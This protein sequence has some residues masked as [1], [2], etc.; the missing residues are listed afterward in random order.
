MSL[1]PQTRIAYP[2]VWS[3]LFLI[4]GGV[5]IAYLTVKD[6]FLNGFL[7]IGLVLGVA[8]VLM[9]M[10]RYIW[11]I[12][13]LFF[14]SIFMIYI[15]RA[16]HSD[17]PTGVIYDFFIAVS[18][19]SVIV[20]A[21]N[22]QTWGSF[23]NPITWAFFILMFY[24]VLEVLNP[25][26]T[27]TAWGVSLRKVTYFLLFVLSMQSVITNRGLHKITYAWFGFA[28]LVA[29]YGIYQEIFG[30]TTQEYNWVI[31]DAERRSIYIVWGKMRK[32]SFLSDPSSFGIF[33]AFS[34]LGSLILA[35]RH[36]DTKKKILYGLMA[37]VMLVSMSFSGT[38]TAY[39]MVVIGFT[40]YVLLTLRSKKTIAIAVT[41]LIVG[42]TLLFSPLGGWQ[43]NRIRS[44]FN[45]SEDASM[46]VRDK[47]RADAQT[48]IQSH[49]F[50][51][52]L[53]TTAINGRKFAPEHQFA[54]FDPDSGYLETALET[55]WVGLI[56]LMAF[57][58]TIMQQGVKH[59]FAAED[60]MLKTVILIYLVPFFA[61]SVA[62]Y[63][64]NAMFAKPVDLLVMITLGLLAQIPQIAKNYTSKNQAFHI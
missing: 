4:A 60:P 21:K 41:L 39:A 44:V 45:P 2:S 15:Q 58:F 25:Y 12:Y 64:Q 6:P 56:I 24:Q 33:M 14:L 40:F 20:S 17:F 18:F 49:P 48:Y 63:S 23:L 46:G 27:F 38:R 53:Y 36:P 28:L 57:V 19:L 47:K 11:G 7:T 16:S 54:G 9:I 37:S 13:F 55:G 52:G 61:L 5:F 34:G 42:G 32:F 1:I 8:G 3:F 59:Y 31:S 30:L 62:H 26:G 35:L 22:Q 50:G 51:G 43:I 10:Y 29:L